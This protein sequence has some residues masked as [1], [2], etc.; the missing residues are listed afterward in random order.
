[1][2]IRYGLATLVDAAGRRTPLDTRWA[3]GL[4][5]ITVPAAALDAA[6]YPAVIDPVIGPERAVDAPPGGF[7]ASGPQVRPSLACLPTGIC[8]VAWQDQAPNPYG[9]GSQIRAA[10][11]AGAGAVS[12]D[13]NGIDVDLAAGGADCGPPL[14]V[15]TGGATA[16]WAVAY[17]C[18]EPIGGGVSRRRLKLARVSEAGV[19]LGAPLTLSDDV[20][21]DV[22]QFHAASN[23]LTQVA[24]AWADIQQIRFTV[25]QAGATMVPTRVPVPKYAVVPQTWWDRPAL[26]WTGSEW[27]LAWRG[28]SSSSPAMQ[29]IAVAFL[30][31]SGSAM[32]V[33]SLSGATSG[34]IIMGGAQGG[35][36]DFLA[37]PVVASDGNGT[38]LV[39]AASRLGNDPYPGT[40]YATRLTTIG[41]DS[42]PWPVP[43]PAT[44]A[45]QEVSGLAAWYDGF[46]FQ[47]LLQ[48]QA[49][50]GQGATL[51]AVP[52]GPFTTVLGMPP[53]LQVSA[54][55]IAAGRPLDAMT[56]AMGAGRVVLA[57]EDRSGASVDVR[58]A[59]WSPPVDPAP[60]ATLL[61]TGG[62]DEDSPAVAFSSG[63]WLVAWEDY[64]TVTTGASVDVWGAVLGQADGSPIGTSALH[65]TTALGAQGGPVAAG[66]PGAFLVA[67]RD[68]RTAGNGGDV[69]ATKVT[70][71]GGVAFPAGTLVAITSRSEYPL[72]AAFDGTDYHLLYAEEDTGGTPNA[73]LKDVRLH[74]TDLFP[75]APVTVATPSDPG[76]R[77]RGRLACRSDG[78][79]VAWSEEQGTSVLVRNP[80]GVSVQVAASGLPL[81]P[82]AAVSAPASTSSPFLVAWSAYEPVA[83]G[84]SL[85]VQPHGLDGAPAGAPTQVSPASPSV[86]AG[87]A[88]AFDG[89]DHVLGWAPDAG[90]LT[91][92]WVQPAGAVRAAPTPLVA[93]APGGPRQ[94]VALAGDGEGRTL[95]AYTV[96]D[97]SIGVRAKR[98]RVRLA[99]YSRL[100]GDA[101]AVGGECASGQCVEGVCCDGACGGGADPCL[102]CNGRG[103]AGTPGRC[104]PTTEACDDGQACTR[105][106]TCDGAGSCRGTAYTCTPTQCQQSST[107]DGSGGCTAV[108]E[109]DD[110]PCDDGAICTHGDRCTGGACGGTALTCTPNQCMVSSTCNGGP[111]CTVVYR[112]TT[113]GCSD[114]NPCTV[115]DHCDAAGGC[116]PGS[117]KVC[118]DLSDPCKGA[119]ACDLGTGECV[120][121][122]A[123]E[124]APCPGGS[125]RAGA[126]ELEGGAIGRA[127]GMSCGS[128]PGGAGALLLAL[129]ALAS[130]RTRR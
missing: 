36:P 48:H 10:R 29:A 51:Q 62:A 76:R 106:D 58:A 54:P 73:A 99:S 44:A 55:V 126:C 27:L 77:L 104:A 121:V 84:R 87:V 57:W 64:R 125:C 63:A 108:N 3:A 98:V 83:G 65:L 123:N 72:G 75:T 8:L 31:A 122:A 119:G 69:Y 88:M 1:A 95:L 94:P 116:V 111:A 79:L 86:S 107:C 129:L 39:L 101:C 13:P 16:E 18:A 130:R 80:A 38:A 34:F 52:V 14:V 92:A 68:D 103:G 35:T 61:T 53:P 40:A 32:P 47:V 120:Y 28:T 100:L 24:V 15:A 97:Q 110:T 4:I 124:G 23:G 66:G 5:R 22:F 127:L 91:A 71:G 118:P 60:G 2:L 117:A 90:G 50:G 19:L 37:Q 74:P 56:G 45:L 26:T 42:T 96:F 81:E 112:G 12:Q 59:G 70:T 82:V 17:T 21:G 33:A 105:S 6:A 85:W 20:F 115:N 7:P 9:G 102:T 89:N 114:G 30:D 109:P 128:G 67:W 49:P 41:S 78:C 11:V 25:L 93:A 46:D 43:L 113:E